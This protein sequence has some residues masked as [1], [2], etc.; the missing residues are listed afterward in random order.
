MVGRENTKRQSEIWQEKAPAQ[1]T[2]TWKLLNSTETA[3]LLGVSTRTL[4]R[5]R[6]QGVIP[7]IRIGRLLRYHR[8]KVMQS[9]E[10]FEVGGAQPAVTGKYGKPRISNSSASLSTSVGIKS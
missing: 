8:V 7:F 4:G 5:L 3:A 9:L 10:A 1:T 2:P 6:A